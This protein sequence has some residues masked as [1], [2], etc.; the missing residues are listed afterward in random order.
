[1]ITP[2][3]TGE[4]V[5]STRFNKFPNPIKSQRVDQYDT[6]MLKSIRGKYTVMHFSKTK[7]VFI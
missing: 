1:M 4:N 2:W 6:D 3:E 5:N 7:K